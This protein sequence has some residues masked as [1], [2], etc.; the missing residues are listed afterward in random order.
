M[1]T[2]A[3]KVSRVVKLVDRRSTY[4]AIYHSR[5]ASTTSSTK[6]QHSTTLDQT[7]DEHVN[8]KIEQT[9]KKTMAE[10]DEELRRKLEGI[11]G[12]GGEAGLELENGQPVA[13]K[14]SVRE[15]MFR[16]I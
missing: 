12:D 9:P 8:S 1:T 2:S 5:Y 13:M 6:N 10:Q 11:S 4:R 14:R 7:K 15:N 3:A 16:L